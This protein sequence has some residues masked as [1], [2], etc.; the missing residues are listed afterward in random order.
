VVAL[1]TAGASA[2][3]A[4]SARVA[5]LFNDLRVIDCH[6]RSPLTVLCSY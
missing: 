6:L 1:A 5:T 2:S 3:I 4:P